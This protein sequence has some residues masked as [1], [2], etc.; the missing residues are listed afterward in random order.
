M[1]VPRLSV[2]GSLSAPTLLLE[3]SR[4]VADPWG[5]IF[6]GTSSALGVSN[7][8]PFRMQNSSECRLVAPVRES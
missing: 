8:T 1:L 4:R 3:P 6:D 2:D 7:F 5:L